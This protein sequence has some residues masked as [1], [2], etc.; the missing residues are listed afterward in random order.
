VWSDDP[1]RLQITIDQVFWKS[2][3]AICLYLFAVVLMVYALMRIRFERLKIKNQLMLERVER[4]REHELSESKTQFFTNVSHEFRTPLSLVLIPLESLMNTSEVPSQLRERIFTAYKNADRMMRLVNELMD[5]NKL[6]G[7]NLKLNIQ[8]GELGR[9]I[10]ETSSAFHE[11]AEKRNI[12]F[13]VVCNVPTLIGWFDKD[14][15][16]RIIFNVLSNA[17]KFTDNEG[18]IKL[19]IN[20]NHS[21]ISDGTLCEC[22]ELVIID[23][24]IGILP[25]ELPRIFEKFYQAK[26]STRISSPGTG[27]GLSLTKALVELHQGRITAESIPDH[28]TTFTIV[29]PIDANAFQIEERIHTPADVVY[30]LPAVDNHQPENTE[31]SNEDKAKILVVEDNF[32]LRAYLAAELEKEYIVLEA[33][34]GDEAF[35]IAVKSNP[36]LIISDIMMP[37]KDGNAFCNAIKSNINTSHIPFILLTAKTT[38][39]DQ[40][41]GVRAGADL[42]ITKPFNIRYLMAHIHQIVAS[43][44][45]LYSRF[46]QDV[47]LMPSKMANNE[48]DQAFLQKAI[49][50]IIQNIQDSQLSV[51]TM[52]DVFNLSRTQ[53][54]RKIKALTGKSAVEFIRAVRMKQAIKLMDTHKFTLSEISFQTGFSSASYFTRCFKDEYGKTPSEYLQQT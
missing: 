29:L 36:D 6:E 10:I 41:T 8:H 12:S 28:A 46:S 45:L 22:L 54:Y 53:V 20:T 44:Q 47:Y 5:F 43:R 18:D 49:D 30:T 16:E 38:V 31:N 23:N 34:D 24:G 39:E 17:F 50:Y 51:D 27:I 9:F 33:G 40:I 11:M 52:S 7:G 19:L 15:L 42:Y 25:D 3:W 35:E 2:W 48:I 32:E 21:I 4:E 1:I 26:S 13:S 14:K 37:R